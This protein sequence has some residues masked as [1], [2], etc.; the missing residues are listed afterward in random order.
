M[1]ILFLAP[2]LPYPADTGGKIRTLNILKQLADFAEIDLV[3]FS[4][5]K[6]D[7]GISRQLRRQVRVN[8]HLVPHREPN[9]EEKIRL[10]FFDTR[11][12]PVAKYF[13]PAMK[14]RIRTLT[15]Q[16]VYDAVHFDHIHMAQYRQELKNIPAVVDEHNVEYRILERCAQ[17]EKNR[18]RKLIYARQIEKTQEYERAAVAACTACTAVSSDDAETLRALTGSKTNVRV[19]PNGVDTEY[20]TPQATR[21]TSHATSHK[22]HTTRHTSLETGDMP[23]DTGRTAHIV[24]TGSMDWLPNDDAM[25][26]FIKD[27]FPLLK[28]Q[29]PD[30]ILD[31]IGKGPSAKLRRLAR[32]DSFINI[33]GR[34]D[35]VRTFIAA[36]AVFI[37]PLRIGGGTR[38]KILEAM[39]MAKPVVS[40]TLGAEGI[41]YTEGKNILLADQPADFAQKILDLLRQPKTAH[42]IGEKGR[43]LVLQ[44][45]DW[46]IIGQLLKDIYYEINK[47]TH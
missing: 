16:C 47:R 20:F 34:V 10:L 41:A 39:A 37:V 24:F 7:A 19:V 25:R 42:K 8:V 2:R 18:V 13:S 12:F 9:W 38:L 29:K 17:V 23:H 28:T 27:I 4:F 46:K 30:I 36:A 26:F 21:H 33:T 32:R 6:D 31:I 45:Y 35:D 1:K 22:P 44:T 5:R 15:A 3:C 43:E 11:P 40:T 14:A